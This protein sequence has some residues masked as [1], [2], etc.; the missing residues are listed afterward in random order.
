MSCLRGARQSSNLL[1]PWDSDNLS[2]RQDHARSLALSVTTDCGFSNPTKGYFQPQSS[3]AFI[4]KVGGN[5]RTLVSRLS[6]F[7][8]PCFQVAVT[9]A[10]HFLYFER[11]QQYVY[12]LLVMLRY[13]A[14]KAQNHVGGKSETP[15]RTPEGG[16]VEGERV[17]DAHGEV[18]L[19]RGASS[20]GVSARP[21]VT[22]V[23]RNDSS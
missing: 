16:A 5:L 4:T 7:Q 1:P 8:V 19:T 22:P 9:H 6:S 10:I 17:T 15:G 21:Q 23:R 3:D 14:G 18:N 2:L 11:S 20:A 13:C 12:W